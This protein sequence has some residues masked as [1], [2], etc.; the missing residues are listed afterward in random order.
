MQV[1][2]LQEIAEEFHPHGAGKEGDEECKSLGMQ[3]IWVVHK[4]SYS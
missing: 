3:Q 2:F 1:V 4:S